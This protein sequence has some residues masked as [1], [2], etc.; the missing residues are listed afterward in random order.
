MSGVKKYTDLRERR[1]YL[2]CGQ[3]VMS[4]RNCE[5]TFSERKQLYVSLEPEKK[6]VQRNRL[7]ILSRTRTPLH[8]HANWVKR[9][10]L[11]DVYV[12]TLK[13]Q[14]CL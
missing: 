4:I 10:E 1:G 14:V 6:L 13:Q 7:C 5:L 9:G 8:P 3:E 2:T 11:E 12:I